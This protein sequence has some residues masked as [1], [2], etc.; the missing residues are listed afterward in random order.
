MINNNHLYILKE[1]NE[2]PLAK[3]PS[4]SSSS[5]IA[6]ATTGKHELNYEM[7]LVPFKAAK[8]KIKKKP[9]SQLQV[10]IKSKSSKPKEKE[11]KTKSKDKITIEIIRR[12]KD[13]TLYSI[14]LIFFSWSPLPFVSIYYCWMAKQAFEK[15]HFEIANAY[16]N[17]TFSLN[18]ISIIIGSI[19]CLGLFSFTIIGYKMAW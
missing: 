5:T 6:A 17:R 16:L 15:K 10:K 4:V 2:L 8:P 14:F 18:I 19:I 1:E 3:R 9:Q 7:S 13:A 11:I 12:Y